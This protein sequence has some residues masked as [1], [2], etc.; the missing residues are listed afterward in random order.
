MFLGGGQTLP[1]LLLVFIFL[2]QRLL[3][4]DIEDIIKLNFNLFFHLY[5]FGNFFPIAF[6]R[7]LNHP[8][9]SN[10]RGTNMLIGMYLMGLIVREGLRIF[11]I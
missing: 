6:C 9:F 2:E 4:C 3:D 7:N 11:N 8:L 10:P 1:G 5:M